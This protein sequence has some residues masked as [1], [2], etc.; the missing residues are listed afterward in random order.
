MSSQPLHAK[1]SASG[2]HR[3]LACPGSVI[4]EED[5]PD[6]T[7]VYAEYGTAGHELGELCLRRQQKA[8]TYRGEFFNRTEEF[9]DG[10]EVDDEMINAVQE[11]VDYC[12]NLSG[13]HTFVE[14]RVDFSEW[15][16]EGFGTSD[17]IKIEKN[18]EGQII[19]CVDLKMGKGV[20]VHAKDNP[21]GMLY[22]LGVLNTLD[23]AFE[24]SDY[25]LVN[26]VIVQPRLDHVDEWLITVNALRDWAENV[27]RPAAK[28]AWEGDPEFHPGDKQC[29]F[30]KAKSACRALAEHSLSTVMSVFRAL[31]DP[32]MPV[33]DIHTLQ[34]DEVAELLPL[35]D[36]ITDWAK[37]LHGHAFDLASNGHNIP[38]YK[39]VMGRAG[40][41]AWVSDAMVES[42]LDSMRIR[43]MDMFQRKLLSPAQM[44]KMLKAQNIPEENI[45]HLWQQPEGKPTIVPNADKREEYVAPQSD[46]F[47]PVPNDRSMT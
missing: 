37:G 16:P 28:A 44:C 33:K 38:G 1:L 14:H 20:R 5:F 4:L 22:A 10:F 34:P 7:S 15:V 19:H 12:N 29:K 9:P 42:E 35:V 41:R 11:Y 31:P 2:S 46:S 36:N 32:G 6:T 8:E 24:F 43:K 27:V 23:M 3:W 21:Q 39:L 13:Q 47:G 26:I 45:T 40:N 30:C 17:Y 25:D 18:D